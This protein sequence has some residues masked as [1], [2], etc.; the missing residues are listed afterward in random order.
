MK[1]PTTFS[2]DLPD[3]DAARARA[4]EIADRTGH[5]VLVTDE[6]GE[7]CR[8]EPIRRNLTTRSPSVF[9]SV[10]ASVEESKAR[11]HEAMTEMHE[12]TCRSRN[13]LEGAYKTLAKANE[14]VGRLHCAAKT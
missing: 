9:K 3:D 7:V 13:V 2:F 11:I 8:V 12:T 1:G 6:A 14:I 4:Q 5:E 10:A